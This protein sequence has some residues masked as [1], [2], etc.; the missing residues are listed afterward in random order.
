[1]FELSMLEFIF[2]IGLFLMERLKPARH[3]PV[4]RQW[5]YHWT[6]IIIFA[7]FWLGGLLL[8]W[9]IVPEL[10]DGLSTLSLWKQV[11]LTYL[12]YSFIAYWYHRLRHSMPLLWRYLHYMHH[13]PAH[14]DTRVTFWRHPLEIVIDSLVVLLVGKLIGA[15]AEVIIGVLI[16]ESMLEIF[17]HSNLHSPKCLRWLGY[18]IQL[19]EQHLIHHQY[20]LHRWN[21]GTITFWDTLFGTVRVPQQWQG[22]VGL[23]EWKNTRQLLFFR[24]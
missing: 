13:S 24:Y 21:Y 19:P 15:S 4:M 7:T 18:F 3:F 16:V 2:F 22:K 1:M 10:W 5:F 6:G 9:P 20:A 8:I 12:L 17:H 14:M 11:M 23:P